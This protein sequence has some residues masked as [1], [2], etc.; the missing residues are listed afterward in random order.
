MLTMGTDALPVLLVCK[1]CLSDV[2][3]VCFRGL[4]GQ[5]WPHTFLIR[6]MHCMH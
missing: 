5:A 1:V 4:M 6:D 2:Q 3:H